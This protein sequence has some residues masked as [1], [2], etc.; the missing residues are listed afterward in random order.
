MESIEARVTTHDNY[1]LASMPPY[2]DTRAAC[3]SKQAQETA[4]CADM[5]NFWQVMNHPD[6]HLFMEAMQVEMDQMDKL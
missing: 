6:V 1:M 2:K 4:N 5:P 3:M